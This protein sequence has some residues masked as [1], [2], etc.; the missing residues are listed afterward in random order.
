MRKIILASHMTMAKGMQ[1]TLEFLMPNVS[2]VTTITAYV[3]NIPVAEDIA[4]VMAE[5]TADDEVLIFTDLLGG[6]VNQAFIPYLKRPHIHLIT[7]VNLPLLLTILVSLPDDYVDPL[8]IKATIQTAR[9][10]LVYVNEHLKEQALDD[11][12]E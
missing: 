2:D 10:Q 5:V 3:E 6:S 7:G 11:E 8:K 9:E 1:E 12:D 4:T